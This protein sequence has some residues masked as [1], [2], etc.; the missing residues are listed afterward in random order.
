MTEASLVYPVEGKY[1]WLMEKQQK[2]GVGRLNGLGGKWEPGDRDIEATMLRE[3]YE[4][5][6]ILPTIYRKMAKIAFHNP[7]DDETL[8]HMLVH[9][10][11]ATGWKGKLKSTNEMKK[12]ARFEIDKNL[13]VKNMMSGDHLFIKE[14]LTG[15]AMH[16]VIVFNDDWSLN[17]KLSHVGVASEEDLI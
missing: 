11:V 17:E 3:A 9:M 10:W 16:G 1:V 5:G 8:R 7:S 15:Q 13:P 6:R 14:I 4:E 2:I 12:P